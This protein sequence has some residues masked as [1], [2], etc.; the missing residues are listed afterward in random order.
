MNQ[1][2]KYQ[3]VIIP[4]ITP[5]DGNGKID[6]ISV[7]KLLNYCINANTIPFILGT[8]GE[9]VSIPLEMR[10]E[11]IKQVMSFAGDRTLVY[12]GIS[13]TCVES[14][15]IQAHNYFD[16]GIR[17]FVCHIP[18][19]YPILPHQ[20]QTFFNSLADNLPAPLMLYN[21]PGTTKISIPLDIIENLSEH[22]NIIGLKDSERSL[23]R[24]DA[25]AERYSGRDDFAIL[26]G[27]TVKSSYAL[28]S[29][30]DGI[31]PSTGNLV[32]HLFSELFEA[33]KEGKKERGEDIQAQID[34]IANF[35]QNNIVLSE[36]IA[37]LKVMLANFGLCGPTVMAPLTRLGEERENQIRKEMKQFDFG[38]ITKFIS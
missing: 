17:V 1:Q 27:W 38:D 21:I 36:V 29:G 5:F 25:L 14:S 37:M 22:P 33:I 16:H 31:V 28:L 18:P 11:L 4:M 26:S 6:L 12:A 24:M 13:D 2:K 8:T 9:N 30:F 10:S 19:Y 35:H 15:L 32:P 20:I 34:P 23:E 7:Q 3:G